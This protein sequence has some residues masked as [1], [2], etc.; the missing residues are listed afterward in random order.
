MILVDSS[1]W[2]DHLRSPVEELNRILLRGEVIQHGYVTAEMAL[3]SLANRSLVIAR[4]AALPQASTVPDSALLAFIEC[5]GLPGS[6]IGLVDA[7]L[8]AVCCGD[9]HQLWTRD[10][11]LRIQAERLGCAYLAG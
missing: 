4:M 3:G 11:R 8:L 9:G 7:H 10:K 6:G 1:V 2:I 5:N